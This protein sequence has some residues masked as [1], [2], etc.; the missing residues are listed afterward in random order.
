MNTLLLVNI[1]EYTDHMK[2][3]SYL[4]F[5]SPKFLSTRPKLAL[6]RLLPICWL[7]NSMSQHW[8]DNSFF[9]Q[10]VWPDFDLLSND[11][12][13]NLNGNM[14]STN[15]Y[16]WKRSRYNSSH[17]LR[18]HRVKGKWIW[19]CPPRNFAY[20]FQQNTANGEAFH[21]SYG[22]FVHFKVAIVVYQIKTIKRSQD[23][24]ASIR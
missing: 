19:K 9:F 13:Q 7:Y 17:F 6:L 8:Y 1:G 23:Y 2:K 24:R 22:D 3:F 20:F 12:V 11:Q 4:H 5:L 14:L 16:I 15:K 18:P 21:I 10:F